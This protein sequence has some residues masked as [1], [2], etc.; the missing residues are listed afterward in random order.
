MT[1]CPHCRHE[2][3]ARGPRGETFDAWSRRW[4]AERRARGVAQER[5]RYERSIKP[6]L[7]SLDVG[8]MTRADV[9]AWVEQTD[10]EVTAGKIRWGTARRRWIQ[11]RRMLADMSR[12]KVRALRVRS[13]SLVADVRGPDRGPQRAA[14]FLY[15]S[16]FL[17]LVSCRRVPIEARRLYALAVYLYPRAGELRA[18][19]WGD[20]DLPSGRVHIHRTRD[21]ENGETH[22][23]KTG[24]DRQFVAERTILPL[25]RA[26]K[27][28]RGR[29]KYITESCE[30]ADLSS[31]LRRHLRIAGCQREALY[32]ADATR[33]PL[34]FHDLRA[35]G[36]TWMALRG[37]SI[38]DIQ[39]R[40][41]HLQILTTQAYMRRGRL[42]ARARGERAFPPLPQALLGKT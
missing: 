25:L 13:D 3:E 16:E 8:L 35:T 11:L 33:R 21:R 37:D 20:I 23:T 17:R 26:L 40:V 41:G 12:S 39:E 1:T 22:A 36:I 9:E 14:T 15:P 18:L 6:M 29:G 31:R 42:L 4:F 7:G 28:R 34:T 27:R 2:I 5:R 38:G 30:G 24:A 32:A 19:E 10:K